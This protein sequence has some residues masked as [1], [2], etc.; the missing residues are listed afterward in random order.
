[1]AGTVRSLRVHHGNKG[2]SSHSASTSRGKSAAK[3]TSQVVRHEKHSKYWSI[4]AN[5]AAIVSIGGA[6][7]S[8][9]NK[10]KRFW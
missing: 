7:Y 1:M 8:L 10:P 6:V 3:R 9:I 5:V 2:N 4:L